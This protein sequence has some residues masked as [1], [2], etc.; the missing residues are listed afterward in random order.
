MSDVP[1]MEAEVLFRPEQDALRFLPE[2]PRWVGEGKLSWVAIQHGAESTVGSLNLLNLQSGENTS[3][4]LRG[5]PGFAI[6]TARANQFVVGLEHR[7]VLFDTAS[8][9]ETLLSDAIDTDVQGTII[10]DGEVF[11]EGVV[12]GAKD[13]KFAEQ[14]AGLYFYRR[15]DGKL[16]RLLSDRIC[17]NGKVLFERD[18]AY[19][20]L[21]ICSPRKQVMAYRLD[22]ERGQVEPLSAVIDL[23]GEPVFP[24][25]MVA[26]PDGRSVIIAIYNPEPAEYGEARQYSIETGQLERVWR[27][28]GSPQV[29]CPC[30]VRDQGS[31]KLV[32]TT[33]VEHMS[34]ERQV[35]APNAGCLFIAETPF[36]DL[37]EPPRI[38]L[39]P[40]A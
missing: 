23:G 21:D 25:G 28:P 20:L 27:C 11:A 32:L 30:L 8:H 13:L 4:E 33:A 10:N 24:D 18:G 38:E 22:I 9:E 16:F 7:L 29:T 40:P 2:G 5:R 12:F 6:P 1:T 34:A 35:G 15:R 39:S 3:Y 19:T 26:T 14:K 17:S 36:M 37:P 31:V